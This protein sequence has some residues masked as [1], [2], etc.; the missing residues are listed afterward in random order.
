MKMIKKLLLNEKS[1][2]ELKDMRLHELAVL[3]LNMDLADKLDTM[4]IDYEESFDVLVEMM[5]ESIE[6]M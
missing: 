2:S 6:E 1:P 4:G 5:A 3:A